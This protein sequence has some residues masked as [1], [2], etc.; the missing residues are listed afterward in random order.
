MITIKDD[1]KEVNVELSLVENGSDIYLCAANS[2][3]KEKIDLIEIGEDGKVATC[4]GANAEW[5]RK[6]GFKFNDGRGKLIIK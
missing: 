6:A 3:T 4:C 5:L 2:I 1:K